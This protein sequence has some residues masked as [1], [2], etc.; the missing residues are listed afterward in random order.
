MKNLLLMA[1]MVV[2]ASTCVVGGQE[3]QPTL[4]PTVSPKGP[5]IKAKLLLEVAYNRALPPAYAVV[6]GADEKPKWMWLTRFARI[7]DRQVL[8]PPIQAVRLES[9]YNGETANVR[10]SLFRGREGFEQEDLVGV[11]QVGVGEQKII[12]ALDQFGIEPFTLTLLNTLTPLPPPPV[13]DYRT[14]SIE[15]VSVQLENSPSPGYRVI[16]RNLSDKNVGALKLEVFSN[17]KQILST[18]WQGEHGQS[19]MKA[20]TIGEKFIP[21]MKTVKTPTGYAPGAPSAITI[22]I[23]SSVFEDF[24]FEGDSQP[25][26]SFKSF[27]LGR[28]I[29]LKHVIPLFEQE[30]SKPNPD[31]IEAA[32]QFKDKF[33]ALTYGNEAGELDKALSATQSCVKPSP[34][35]AIAVEGMKLELLRELDQIITTRPLPQINFK[36]WMEEKRVLFSAWLARL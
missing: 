12:S 34:S 23:A 9:V 31:H 28:K 14:T 20:G 26:C 18:L 13:F 5:P 15:V 36:S 11:Y 2:V 4:K 22:I 1:T 35:T 27:Q 6:N 7:P 25:A 30:L 19:V 21:V 33:S 29:W 10:V 16:F 3:Q 8:Q 17:G 24:S 32:R